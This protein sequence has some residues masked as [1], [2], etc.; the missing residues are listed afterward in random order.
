MMLNRAPQRWNKTWP[1][2]VCA[3]AHKG[4]DLLGIATFFSS[5]LCGMPAHSPLLSWR[6][7]SESRQELFLTTSSLPSLHLF[8][9]LPFFTPLSLSNPPWGPHSELFLGVVWALTRTLSWIHEVLFSK[10]YVK[11]G[12]VE[13]L[14]SM[15]SI[16]NQC[17]SSFMF[18]VLWCRS[19]L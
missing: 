19:L 4:L 17:V 11:S 1:W 13:D 2:P 8:I 12:K 15:S 7:H 16:L 3:W 10:L 6:I 5:R 18:Y 14:S 9:T